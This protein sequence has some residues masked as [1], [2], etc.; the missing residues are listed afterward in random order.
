MTESELER[1]K[2]VADYEG[3]YQVSDQGRVRRIKP[4]SGTHIDKVLSPYE[5]NYGYLMVSL[6]REGE[7][8]LLQVHRLVAE[9]F[10]GSQPSPDHEVN[11]KNGDKTDNRVE[12]L[13]WVTHAENQKHALKHGLMQSGE[14]CHR[15]RLTSR[16]VKKIRR[17]YDTGR[18]TQ[19]E[20]G[21]RFGTTRANV[22]LIVRGRTWQ[23]AS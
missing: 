3:I 23:G 21:E 5:N 2:D 8:A 4:A 16:E 13:E 17:L 15:S 18:H 1:W 7:R 9:V 11:H 6:Y 22:S 14:E 19:Q 20:L 12:N 10:L